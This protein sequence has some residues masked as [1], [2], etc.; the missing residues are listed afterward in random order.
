MKEFR[1]P[2]GLDL[3]DRLSEEMKKTKQQWF[4]PIKKGSSIRRVV[5]G[6][7]SEIL[8]RYKYLEWNETKGI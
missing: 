3:F 5:Y 7:K 2:F 8:K 6:T 1:I 4:I